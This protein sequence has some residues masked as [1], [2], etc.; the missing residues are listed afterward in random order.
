MFETKP[1]HRSP[2]PN[3]LCDVPQI[4]CLYVKWDNVEPLDKTHIAQACD[5]WLASLKER[6]SALAR[7]AKAYLACLT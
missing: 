4:H 6:L 2:E 1:H 5:Q 7:H 3:Q